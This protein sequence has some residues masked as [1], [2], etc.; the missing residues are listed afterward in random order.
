MDKKAKIISVC[1]SALMGIFLFTAWF[2][3]DYDRWGDVLIFI[4]CTLIVTM[5]LSA[6]MITSRIEGK[7]EKIENLLK[8]SLKKEKDES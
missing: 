2:F 4:T 8:E 1:G 3:V 5:L 6:H 7:L